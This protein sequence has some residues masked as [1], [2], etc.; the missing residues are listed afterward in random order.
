MD[1][2][3]IYSILKGD[4]DVASL[5]FLGVFPIDLIPTT[6]LKFPCCLVI[7][8]KPSTHPGEHWVAVVKTEENNGI[9]FDSYGSSTYNLPEIGE[10][11]ETCIDWSYNSVRLQSSYSTVCGQYTIF[12]IVHL[13]KGYTLN[14]I[15]TLL[16]D[17]GDL[18]S[19]DAFI[20]NYI[21]NKYSDLN[22]NMNELQ[23]VDFPF[24]FKQISNPAQ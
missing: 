15:T 10:L 12:T 17:C 8:T 6:A 24:I 19:N 13:A 5:N 3:Q 20:F 14:H 4:Q 1:S 7:N 18:Y 22:L 16:N 23:V 9:Y 2:R 21:K 11:F